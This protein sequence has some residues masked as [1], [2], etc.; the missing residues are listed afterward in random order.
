MHFNKKAIFAVVIGVL[1][2]ITLGFFALA[3][4]ASTKLKALI[5]EEGKNAIN[6]EL[7]LKEVKLVWLNKV[8]ITGLQIQKDGKVIADIPKINLSIALWN[9]FANNKLEIIESLTVYSPTLNL[10]MDAQKHWNISELL[11]P[12]PESNNKFVSLVNLRDANINADING[13]QLKLLLNGSVDARS[14]DDNYAL[15]LIAD[16]DCIGALKLVG[17]VNVNRQGRMNISSE[18]LELAP[19]KKMLDDYIKVD[20]LEGSIANVDIIWQDQKGKKLLNGKFE[21]QNAQIVYPY[22]HKK[23]DL[24]VTGLVAFRDSEVNFKQTQVSINGQTIIVDGGVVGRNDS[25]LPD[26]LKIAVKQIEL[27]K[28]LAEPELQ[29]LIDAESVF[30]NDNGQLSFVGSIK[31][32][33]IKFK[34]YEFNK[35]DIPFNYKEN[36]LYIDGAQVNTLNGKL[37]AKAVYNALEKRYNLEVDAQDLNLSGLQIEELGGQ[38]QGKFVASGKI[39]QG[40]SGFD[41]AG[42]LALS[43]LNYKDMLFSDI[44]VDVF[45]LGSSVDISNGSATLENMGQVAFFGSLQKSDFA[46]LYLVASDMPLAFITQ[47]LG[48]TSTG[49]VNL[50]LHLTGDLRD[51]SIRA[52]VNT[53]QAG[54]IAGLK[55]NSLKA[56]FINQNKILDIKNLSIVT[57]RILDTTDGLYT[58]SGTVNLQNSMPALDLEINTKNV[59]ADDVMRDNFNLDV[60]GYFN[61]KINVKGWLNNPDVSAK[62][63]LHEGSINGVAVHYVRG[64]GTYKDG[65]LTVPSLVLDSLTRLKVRASGVMQN[66]ELNFDLVAKDVPLDT[67]PRL[68]GFDATGHISFDGKVTGKVNRPQF[69]GFVNSK[70]LGVYGQKFTDLVGKISS[71]AGI[72]TEAMVDFKEAKGGEFYFSGGLDYAN[73]YAYGKFIVNKAN[74]EPFLALSSDDYGVKGLLDGEIYLNRNGKGSGTEIIGQLSQA[75][76]ADL[77]IQEA[78][79]NLF[80]TRERFLINK[81]QATQGTG[82]LQAFGYADFRGDANITVKGEN[83]SAQLLAVGQK[84]GL[85]I[86]GSMNIDATITGKTLRPDVN[87]NFNILNGG[88]GDTNFDSLVGQLSINGNERIDIK[89]LTLTKMGFSSTLSG[90]IPIDLFRDSKNRF[91]NNSEMDLRL[92]TEDG[93]LGVLAAISSI[94]YSAGSM[95]GDLHITGTLEEPQIY[96]DMRIK[97]GVVKFDIFKNPLTDINLDL[98]FNGQYI[99]LKEASAKMGKGKMKFGGNLNIAKAQTQ[100]Y[101]LWGKAENIDLESLYIKGLF[102]GEFSVTPQTNRNRPLLKASTTLENITF[103]IPGIPDFNSSETVNLGLDVSLSIGK[104][105][106]IVSKSFCDLYLKGGMQLRGTAAYPVINGNIEVDRGTISYLRSQFKVE[107][108]TISYPLPGTYVPNVNIKAITKLLQYDITLQARGPVSNMELIL[109]SNPPRSQQDLFRLLTLKVESNSSEFNSAD[110]RGLLITGLQM[111]VFGD[112]EYVVRNSLGLNDFRIYQGLINT[113]TALDMTGKRTVNS[114]DVDNTYNI[115]V[116]KYLTDKLL[117]GYSTAVDFKNYMLYAQYFIS[118]SFNIS[119]GM[120]ELRNKKF[121]IEYKITF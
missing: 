94:N 113:G 63:I 102:T 22:E 37:S 20:K 86:N 78:A 121:A 76:I 81:F 32:E 88:L 108:A 69:V 53:A 67:I 75:S 111:S 105:V 100:A 44:T 11:K 82:T 58:M 59:R 27:G 29:G 60:T 104:N 66:D 65:V 13:Q 38:A 16:A 41:L 43:T 95:Y 42:S 56:E 19:L 91:G 62:M 92:K 3:P 36:K 54:S 79:I 74:I 51:P 89:R 46:N 80:L 48:V 4:M 118:R 47:P 115:L 77:P 8:Q 72:N 15:D 9:V 5:L 109:S 101:S 2:S 34:D 50:N 83:L 30:K 84:K 98:H 23:F 71:D 87:A 21:A 99:D 12:S 33:K 52:V 70:E 40:V 35:I 17:L 114:K 107:E 93:N 116:S 117:L 31:S 106:R 6:G 73:N 49:N 61:S 14:G 1:L 28:L 55:Y 10:A 25:W 103:L 68:S 7:S 57:S 90:T 24:N 119:A 64:E 26:N 85:R 112:V 97:N 39:E 110:A 18:Q 120:D 96:G 45:K